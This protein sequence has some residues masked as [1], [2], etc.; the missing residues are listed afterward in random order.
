[1]KFRKYGEN[2]PEMALVHGGPGACGELSLLAQTL[3]EKVSVLEPLLTPPSL[4]QQLIE[5]EYLI[6]TYCKHPTVILGHSA[7]ALLSYIFT[8]KKPALIKKLI[9]VGS[10][11]FEEPCTKDIMKTRLARLNLHDKKEV[12]SLIK[13]LKNP[14]IQNKKIHLKKLGNLIEKADSYDTISSETS[15]M[16]F[17]YETYDNVWKEFE[18]I[19]RTGILLAYGKHIHCPVIVIHGDYDPHPAEKIR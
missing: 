13:I 14:T 16:N 1:M 10:G 15:S 5:L 12:L 2:L 11:C 18:E 8:A 9:L 3:S 6:R 17:S 19:R 7:G 4:N